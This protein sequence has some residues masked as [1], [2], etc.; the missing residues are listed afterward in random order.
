MRRARLPMA[1]RRTHCRCPRCG[2]ADTAR[3][4]RA[5]WR[6]GDRDSAGGRRRQTSRRRSRWRCRT[7]RWEAAAQQA[8]AV[9]RW[10]REAIR[11]PQTDLAGYV[12][13]ILKAQYRPDR[14]MHPGH[15]SVLRDEQVFSLESQPV[16]VDGH[17]APKPHIDAAHT[18][19][20][21][22]LQP[23]TD[24]KRIGQQVVEEA[25]PAHPS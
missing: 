6:A 22:E 1:D 15:V 7:A 14:R 21:D 17:I 3:I 24:V 5:G 23:A 12:P 9:P 18:S 19:Y 2:T 25:G 4:P 20:R 10:A 13:R 11:S 8:T 16:A